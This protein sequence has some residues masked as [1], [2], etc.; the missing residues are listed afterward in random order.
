MDNLHNLEVH[1][2]GEADATCS[3]RAWRLLRV[4]G[5]PGVESHEDRMRDIQNAFDAHVSNVS[6]AGTSEGASSE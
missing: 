3:C 5:G 2:S 1:E 4:T 6:A